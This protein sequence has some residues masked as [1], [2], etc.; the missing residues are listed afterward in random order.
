MGKRASV[1]DSSA[2]RIRTLKHLAQGGEFQE[3]VKG[4][5]QGKIKAPQATIV[6]ICIV[7]FC[8]QTI[9]WVTI[10]ILQKRVLTQTVTPKLQPVTTELYYLQHWGV[11]NEVE[12]G[13]WEIRVLTIVLSL[14]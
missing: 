5:I 4:S 14:N 10:P 13:C 7:S 8:P 3:A 2:G 6:A 1:T 9:K 12:R 11:G